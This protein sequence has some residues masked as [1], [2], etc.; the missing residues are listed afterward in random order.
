MQFERQKL[1]PSNAVRK[2]KPWIHCDVYGS[3]TAH[4][5]TE[6]HTQSNI[7]NIR[8]T[9]RATVLGNKRTIE[10]WSCSK[11]HYRF[12]CVC[13][14]VCVF[15]FLLIQRMNRSLKSFMLVCAFVKHP[16][17]SHNYYDLY[18]SWSVVC[19]MSVSVQ[20]VLPRGTIEGRWLVH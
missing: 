1:E 10:L 4:T 13:V 6:S 19:T 3:E 15:Q 2:T 20:V 11:N 7:R 16:F 17:L 8:N 9:S 5:H 14:C 18:F 12:V